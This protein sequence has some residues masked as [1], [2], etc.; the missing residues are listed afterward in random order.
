MPVWAGS[1]GLR[2]NAKL[3]ASVVS[4]VSRTASDETQTD[5]GWRD[6]IELDFWGSSQEPV[7]PVR[8][9]QYLHIVL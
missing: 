1:L 9:L 8:A 4:L 5:G 7:C 2:S 3:Q 6:F